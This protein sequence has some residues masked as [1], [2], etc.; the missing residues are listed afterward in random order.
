[1]SAFGGVGNI[2]GGVGYQGS[3]NEDLRAQQQAWCQQQYTQQLNDYL[4]QQTHPRQSQSKF[5]ELREKAIDAEFVVI[6]IDGKKLIEER[7]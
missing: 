7:K 5:N 2:L 4:N 1:M 3:Y 6:E